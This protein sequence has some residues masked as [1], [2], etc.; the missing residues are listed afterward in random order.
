MGKRKKT[1][2][3]IDELNE[4]FDAKATAVVDR[5]TVQLASCAYPKCK[6]AFHDDL[7]HPYCSATCRL[8]HLKDGGG[9]RK[10]KRTDEYK[11]E[12]ASEKLFAFL[13][14]CERSHLPRQRKVGKE[15]IP[16]KSPVLPSQ[17]AYAN[18]LGFTSHTL[19]NWAKKHNEFLTALKLIDQVQYEMLTSKGLS[20]EYQS[21]TAALLLMSEHDM[22]E[23]QKT[24]HT[25]RLGI[26][27]QVY[28]LA[29][30][31]DEEVKVDYEQ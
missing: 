14:Y 15:M 1:V 20:G 19:V 30:Q 21:K 24:D 9:Q 31:M 25:H 18:Y 13:R 5:P 29:D 27:R 6:E 2:S 4:E 26:V 11:S 8:F 17:K 7:Y 12:Y 10:K 16:V 28:E 23:R 22:S 3:A